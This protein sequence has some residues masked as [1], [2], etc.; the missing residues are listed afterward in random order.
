MNI[1]S[2]FYFLAG[3]LNRPLEAVRAMPA[4]EFAAWLVHLGFDKAIDRQTQA[5]AKAKAE[6]EAGSA[7]F[8][9]LDYRAG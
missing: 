1:L 8:G 5:K 9:E 6:A 2:D 4:A 3:E 7:V